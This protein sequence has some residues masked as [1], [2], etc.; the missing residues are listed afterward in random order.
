MIFSI[1]IPTT[2]SLHNLKRLWASLAVQSSTHKTEILLS[3][4]GIECVTTLLQ[5]LPSLPQHF[6]A[7]VIESPSPGIAIA[8]NKALQAAQGEYVVFLDDDCHLPHS[9]YL[10][11]IFDHFTAAPN[12]G[13]AGEYLTAAQGVS[14]P[15][16]F[17][18]YMSNLWLRSFLSPAH[19]LSVTLGGCAAFPRALIVASQARFEENSEKAAEEYSFS[20]HLLR[21]GVNISYSPA[22]SV[23]HDTGCSW[24]SLWKKSWNHGRALT[25]YPEQRNQHRWRAFWLEFKNSPMQSLYFSPLLFAY[26][27]AGRVSLGVKKTDRLVG[28]IRK[29]SLKRS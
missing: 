3:A 25:I 22:W 18:N 14:T 12:A 4:T 7:R 28:S 21:H 1:I 5:T 19:S 26:L 16:A 9:D 20:Q 13:L 10:K 27:V 2:G 6:H 23:Y 11:N 24:R 29:P 8:R 17:Y 15:S